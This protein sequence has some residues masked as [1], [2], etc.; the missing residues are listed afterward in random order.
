MKAGRRV[1]VKIRAGIGMEGE[2][3]LVLVRSGWGARHREGFMSVTSTEGLA[4]GIVAEFEGLVKGVVRAAKSGE[5]VRLEAI[6]QG[7]RR[8]GREWLGRMLT[9][10]VEQI[11]QVAEAGV[12]C[13]C[14]SVPR[15]KG[16]Q[17]RSQ[18]TLAGKLRYRRGYFYCP[19]CRRGW[20]PLDERLGMLSGQFSGGL[21]EAM[22][23]VG[24]ALPF[25]PAATMLER[26]AGVGVSASTIERLTEERGAA[27]ERWRAEEQERV[28]SEPPIAW[29]PRAAEAPGQWVAG[30]DA[31]MTHFGDGWHEAKVG[32]ICLARGQPTQM[33]EPEVL[34]EDQTYVAHVGGIEEAGAKLY[35]EVLRRG[36]RPETDKVVCL[37]DGAPGIWNQFAL[38]FPYRV[39]ILDWYHAME[40][41]WAAGKAGLGEGKPETTAWA[42]AQET[43]LWQGQAQTVIAALEALAQAS[44]VE[45]VTR[46]LNYFR[47]NQERLDYARYR[48]SGYPIGSGMVE[49]ACKQVVGARL[50]GPGMRWSKPG[51]QAVLTLRC[52]LASNR[53]SQDWQLTA[54]L[55]K[56]A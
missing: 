9:H 22:A 51:A 10:A 4:K 8:L 41:L 37:A 6:E 55:P 36:V 46:E 56:A 15:Y 48:A 43:L 54:P 12:S 19:G 49:S 38:H 32:V 11:R 50:K 39:E 14:G 1:R 26:L 31:T 3:L 2:A 24:V 25:A 29:G 17:W 23:L 30:L 28:M 21:S 47:T 34:V 52:S 42:K 40:H 7:L 53:W 45:A 20:Y 27:L 33:V 13:S 44:G 16:E 5:E 35:C 18:E